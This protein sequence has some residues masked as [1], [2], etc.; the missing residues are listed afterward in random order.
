M[1]FLISTHALL[2]EFILDTRFPV[3]GYWVYFFAPQLF[4]F[5]PFLRAAVFVGLGVVSAIADLDV[6]C[7]C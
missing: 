2:F 3:P 5:L 6:F 1:L 4:Y 7:L